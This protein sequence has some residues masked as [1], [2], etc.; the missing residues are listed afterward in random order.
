MPRAQFI[1]TVSDRDTKNAIQNAKVELFSPGTTTLITGVWTALT[2]GSAINT[3]GNPLLTDSFGDVIC[4]LDTAQTVDVRESDNTDTAFF[5]SASSTA[6]SFSPRTIPNFPA[7]GSSAAGGGNTTATYYTVNDE[8]ADLPNS[9]SGTLQDVSEKAQPS[10]YA[11]LDSSGKV[12]LAQLPASSALPNVADYGSNVRFVSLDGDNSDGMSWVKAFNDPLAAIADITGNHGLVVLD[13]NQTYVITSQLRLPGRVRLMVVNG[14]NG[15][16]DTVI[17]YNGAALSG[18][19]NP[20]FILGYQANAGGGAWTGTDGGMTGGHVSGIWFRKRRGGAAVQ[21]LVEAMNFQNN[22]YIAHCKFGDSHKEIN[23][24][25]GSASISQLFIR[26][27]SGAP[28]AYLIENIRVQGGQYPLRIQTPTTDAG[29]IRSPMLDTDDANLAA[30]KIEALDAGT[31]ATAP[32]IL[33]GGQ[34]EVATLASGSA[35]ASHGIQI[36]NDAIV[37]LQGV[38]INGLG[39]AS[40]STGSALRYNP[41]LTFPDLPRIVSSASVLGFAKGWDAPNLATGD[42]AS[43]PSSG[44]NASVLALWPAKFRQSVAGPGKI[45][46]EDN[47]WP[48]SGPYRVDGQ[49][50]LVINTTP[51]PNRRYFTIRHN[52]TWYSNELLPQ[53]SL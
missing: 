6:I 35:T 34:V 12:P 21:Y 32:L 29:E 40:T 31:A 49:E 11:S 44:S 2:G 13:I 48:A 9:V 5:P 36:D 51:S 39:G 22:G 37:V 10:G 46:G 1:W 15:Q 45:V 33:S 52:G 30:I 50:Y 28:S 41:A 25:T 16:A 26:G 43:T 38:P 42:L 53:T 4:Y 24:V 20:A 3:A 14:A 8:T 27:V 7:G 18:V 23:S 17:E 19:N 47:D